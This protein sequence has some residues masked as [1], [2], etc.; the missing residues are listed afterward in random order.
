MATALEEQW[1]LPTCHS[2]SFDDRLGLLLDRKLAW[3]DN[4]RL[5][6]LRKHAKLNYAGACLEDLDRRP[7]RGLDE[8]QLATLASGDWIRQQHNLLLTGPTGVGKTWLACALG[9]QACRQGYSTLYLRT[10]RLLEQLRI[11]H[12][13][14]SLSRTLQQLAKVDVLILD[15]WALAP[16][17][18]NARHDLLEVIDDRAGSRSTVLTSQLPVD[19]WHGWINDPTVADALLDRLVHSAYRIVMK[20]EPLRRKKTEEEAAS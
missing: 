10:P 3:R 13:D 8:R 9:N 17:E 15:D 4:K 7:G 6:R 11:A 16:L 20:G 18:D 2:L 12:G 1:T 19:H 5:E 14:G